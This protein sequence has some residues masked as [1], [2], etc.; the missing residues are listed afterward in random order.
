MGNTAWERDFCVD[1]RGNLYVKNRGEFYH[2]YMAVDKYAPDGK[3]LQT[4]LWC[5]SDGAFG[6]KIDP[7][8]NF[9]IAEA[10]K[11]PGRKWPEEFDGR[12]PGDDKTEHW[13]N[14]TYTSYQPVCCNP[15]LIS[16]RCGSTALVAALPPYGRLT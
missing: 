16:A 9:Y 10:V 2:G 6:P 13:Y 14:Y 4:V 3:F 1:R 8:G 5:V 12:L 15:A 11:P 7:Q